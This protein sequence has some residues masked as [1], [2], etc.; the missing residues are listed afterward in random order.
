MSEKKN[1]GHIKPGSTK[2]VNI[3]MVRFMGK[4]IITI[5]SSKNSL[6]GPM[7]QSIE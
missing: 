3:V 2:V 1:R 4:N 6:C 7:A 5:L